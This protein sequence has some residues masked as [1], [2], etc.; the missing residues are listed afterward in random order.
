MNAYL[1]CDKPKNKPRV[2]VRVCAARCDL[3]EE[4][5]S[6]KDYREFIWVI[7]CDPLHDK[8]GCDLCA[9]GA[10]CLTREVA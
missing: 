9:L 8:T 2:H 4:C 5:Q 1:F 7:H 10:A 6:Y 3:R